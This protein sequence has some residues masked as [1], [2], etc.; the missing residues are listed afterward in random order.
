MIEIPGFIDLSGNEDGDV[1]AACRHDSH[2]TGPGIA[3]ANYAN[4]AYYDGGYGPP[5]TISVPTFKDVAGFFGAIIEHA[6]T[7]AE[8]RS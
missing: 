3:G 5:Y 2:K 4:I 1:M 8:V 6:E 7:H